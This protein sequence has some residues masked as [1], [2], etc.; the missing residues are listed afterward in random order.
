MYNIARKLFEVEKTR[1]KSFVYPPRFREDSL[2]VEGDVV[3]KKRGVPSKKKK[4]DVGA[5]RPRFAGSAPLDSS[6]PVAA[7][8]RCTGASENAFSSTDWSA[9]AARLGNGRSA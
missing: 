4:S 2:V 9:N 6:A 7:I 8:E 5:G 1:K 3:K